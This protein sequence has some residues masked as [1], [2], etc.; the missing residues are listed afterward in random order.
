MSQAENR[1]STIPSRRTV[2][3]G[4]PAVVW[5]PEP[6]VNGL[7]IAVATP[8]GRTDTRNIGPIAIEQY[9]EALR[10]ARSTSQQRG[11][12]APGH[13]Q[14]AVEG[15]GTMERIHGLGVAPEGPCGQHRHFDRA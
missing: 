12:R 5:R 10:V 2:L 13:R 8:S 11:P 9:F 6:A 3:A 14:G 15:P 7:A 1:N 4:A